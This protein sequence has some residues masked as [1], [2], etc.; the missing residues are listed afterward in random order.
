MF[1]SQIQVPL[2]CES[3]TQRPKNTNTPSGRFTPAH[4]GAACRRLPSRA[5][6][7]SLAT[8]NRQKKKVALWKQAAEVQVGDRV[9]RLSWKGDRR[10]FLPAPQVLFGAW[11]F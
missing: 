8:R 3:L 5:M 11:S 1:P 4:A 9:S 7:K 6:P 10:G 2:P